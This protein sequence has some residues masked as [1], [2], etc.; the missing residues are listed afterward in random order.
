MGGRQRHKK[1]R[2]VKEIRREERIGVNFPCQAANWKYQERP[3]RKSHETGKAASLT[4]TNGRTE[5]RTIE[6]TSG[7]R[8]YVSV[9]P[10]W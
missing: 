2:K 4:L 3:R 10:A 8:Q 7:L 9:L 1:K 5:G 6:I